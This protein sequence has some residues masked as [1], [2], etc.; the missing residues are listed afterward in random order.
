MPNRR[1]RL[2]QDRRQSRPRVL[3]IPVD[4]PTDQRL[5]TYITARKIKPPLHP[6]TRDRLN[7]LRQQLPQHNLLRKVLG[8]DHHPAGPRRCTP[9]QSLKPSQYRQ[10]QQRQPKTSPSC[11]T[12]INFRERRA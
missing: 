9:Q 10:H 11:L 4:P 1:Q 8:P 6:L 7:L 2:L 12:K 3:H 5:L